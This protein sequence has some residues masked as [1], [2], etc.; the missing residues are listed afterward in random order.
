MSSHVTVKVKG[1][2]LPGLEKLRQLVNEANRRVLVGIPVGAGNE[3]RPDGK[4]SGTSLALVAASNE[5][6]V[7]LGTVQGQ[8]EFKG[9]KTK[10]VELTVV[11]IPERSFLRAGLRKAAPKF[12]R[13]NRLNLRLIL[14]G[15]ISVETALGQLGAYAA[16]Q[17]QDYITHGKFEPNAPST[18]AAKAPKTHPLENTLQLKQG[19][20]FVVEPKRG[21]YNERP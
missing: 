14:L 4:D 1:G 5:F 13:L 20:T 2:N 6:G 15:D 8:R 12:E 9:G 16:G 19:I 3:K 11:K 17:V 21:V 10:D 7:T 18:L